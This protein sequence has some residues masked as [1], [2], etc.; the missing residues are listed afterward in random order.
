MSRTIIGISLLFIS[1]FIYIAKLISTAILTSH[2]QIVNV[3]NWEAMIDM[4][5]S[6]INWTILIPLILGVGL[7]LLEE[8]V[9]NNK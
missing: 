9:K 2:I 3:E 4:S 5:P 1:A 8:F 6:F 7:I